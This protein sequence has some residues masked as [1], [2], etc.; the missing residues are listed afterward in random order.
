VPDRYISLYFASVGLTEALVLA[1]SMLRLPFERG[2][3]AAGRLHQNLNSRFGAAASFSFTSARGALSAGLRAVGLQPEDEVLLSSFTCLA[4]PSAVLAAGAKPTYSDIDPY[5]LNA[6]PESIEAA[7]SPKTRVIVLQHTLGNPAPV[8]SVRELARSRG[9]IVIEDCALAVG[10]KY[11]REMVG[12]QGDAAIFSME[13]SKTISS[14][15]GGIL[16]VNDEVLAEKV[17]SDYVSYG[18][19]PLIRRLRMGVQTL[20]SGVCYRPK[21]HWIG[22][23]V[24]A[25]CFKV[26]LFRSSTPN[27]EQRGTFAPDFISRMG[28]P[29]ISLA[30][31]QWN[32]LDVIARECA[33]NSAYIRHFLKRL[34]Y[35][36]LADVAEDLGVAPRVPFLVANRSTISAWFSV[37]GVELGS[38]FDGPLT[39]LPEAPAYNYDRD[40]FPRASFIADHIV[41]LPCHNRLASRDLEKMEALMDEYAAKHPEDL[42]I[43]RQL[44]EFSQA[45]RLNL[46]ES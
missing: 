26:G 45:R 16:V 46:V 2:E 8:A 27:A 43:Q 6:S 37:N 22:K 33:A 20:I 12:S 25:L 31:H 3:R 29:Q 38:W 19:L 42:A 30:A 28:E 4:V 32:R 44:E 21:L 34:G 9:I 14:G 39:P 40:S 10:T 24:V 15:W 1:R 17:K 5:S 11:Q 35:I 23:Y 13:L 18:P 7:I 41:N 36:P